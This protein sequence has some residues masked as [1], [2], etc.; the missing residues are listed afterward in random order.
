MFVLV[1]IDA[2]DV[3][4]LQKQRLNS[5]GLTDQADLPVPVG[6]SIAKAPLVTKTISSPNRQQ[7]KTIYVFFCF[8]RLHVQPEPIS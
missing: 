6:D 2:D 1:P 5:Y 4:L 7:A 3:Q 8:C